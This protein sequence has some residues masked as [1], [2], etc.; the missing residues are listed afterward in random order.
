MEFINLVIPKDPSSGLD[1]LKRLQNKT[2][3][4]SIDSSSISFLAQSLLHTPH[5][6]EQKRVMDA[7]FPELTSWTQGVTIVD[8]LFKSGALE[9][10]LNF[11]ARLICKCWLLL[12]FPNFTER[13]NSL[14]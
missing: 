8:N 1:I 12:L 5:G 14:V 2:M 10:G 7:L 13:N 11:C 4:G 9:E 6:E 3:G